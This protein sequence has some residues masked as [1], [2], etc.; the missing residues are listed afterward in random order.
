M[1][2]D[3]F[4]QEISATSLV[5]SAA[6]PIVLRTSLDDSGAVATVEFATPDMASTAM[7]LDGLPINGCGVRIRRT[8]Q[9]VAAPGVFVTGREAEV[10]PHLVAENVFD[11]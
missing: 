6:D 3:F 4:V 8:P 11:G 9:Y 7:N 5:K 10:N 2:K 1:I